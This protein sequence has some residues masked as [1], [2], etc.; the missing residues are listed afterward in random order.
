M[1]KGKGIVGSSKSD[2]AMDKMIRLIERGGT[3]VTGTMRVKPDHS[4]EAQLKSSQNREEELEELELERRY[5]DYL[6]AKEDVMESARISFYRQ[7]RRE[8]E[9]NGLSESRYVSRALRAWKAVHR[10]KWLSR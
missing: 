3:G 7:T 5:P 1:G 6:K 9:E 2:R 4:F 8:R 10:E